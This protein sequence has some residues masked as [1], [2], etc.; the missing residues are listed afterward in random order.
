MS[1]DL[2]IGD[3]HIEEKSIPE[4]EGIF[5]EILSIKADSLVQLGDL[6]NNNRPTPME[7]RFATSIVKKLKKKFKD[8]T[9]ISGT[10]IH[11]TLHDVSVIEFFKELGINAVKGDYI[12]DN[13][14][15]GHFMVNE[16]KLSYGTGRCGIKDLA[17]YDKVFLGHL[18]LFQELKVDKIYHPGSIRF[19]NFNELSDPFKRIIILEDGK[20]TFKRLKS[21]YPMIQV[22]SLAELKKIE[23][24]KKKVRLVINSFE[25]FKK[26]VN[27]IGA[28]RHK[29]HVF[30]VK[31]DF[32]NK[33][34]LNMSNTLATTKLKDI[35]KESIEKIKDVEVRK[36][37]KEVLE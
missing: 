5:K 2:V 30:K 33:P 15:Y 29:F 17:K 12:R 11:D 20:I 23:P 1:K 27:E 14:L 6:F 4:L 21:P 16:S 35:L 13:I 31:L 26:E 10:G 9:I 28:W 8:V 3:V 18:H 7:L 25:Q 22:R 34:K 36:L 24:G 19:Q 32:E 37:L